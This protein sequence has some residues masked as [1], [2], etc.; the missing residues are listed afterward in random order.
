MGVGG[1]LLWLCGPMLA[2]LLG[3]SLLA[4]RVKYVPLATICSSLWIYLKKRTK[5]YFRSIP[6]GK[7]ETAAIS[8]T[9]HVRFIW[10]LGCGNY[11]CQAKLLLY[12]WCWPWKRAQTREDNCDLSDYCSGIGLWIGCMDDT[13]RISCKKEKMPHEINNFVYTHGSRT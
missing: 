10:W 6:L 9:L 5:W 1:P 2:I 12:F 8:K 11:S 4:S 3:P 7:W 13:T